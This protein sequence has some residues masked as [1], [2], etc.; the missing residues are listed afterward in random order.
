MAAANA[1]PRGL[2]SQE[3]SPLTV[4]LRIRPISEEVSGARAGLGWFVDGA[5]RL[6]VLSPILMNIPTLHR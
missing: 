4:A 1:G 3:M 2:P 6:N 5:I